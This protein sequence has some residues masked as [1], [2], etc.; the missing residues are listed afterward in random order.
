MKKLLPLLLFILFFQAASATT[1][2]ITN[3]GNSFAPAS[4]TIAVGDTVVFVLTSTHDA[5]EVSQTTWNS[6]GTTSLTGGF[7]TAFGGGTVF[8][9]QLGIG[10]HYY[11]CT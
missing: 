8:P 9:A 3:S 2:T 5:R 11:V 1:F 10:T 7:Q 6:N 4:M